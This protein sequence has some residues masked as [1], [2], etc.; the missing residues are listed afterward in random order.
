MSEKNI[1]LFSCNVHQ[2]ISAKI[3]KLIKQ[4]CCSK[5]HCLNDF[6]W[7]FIYI[8]V[9]ISVFRHSYIYL[10]AD[11][12]CWWIIIY[13]WVFE[14]GLHW[15]HWMCGFYSKWYSSF[16][17]LPDFWFLFLLYTTSHFRK[18]FLFCLLIVRS[19]CVIITIIWFMI[20]KFCR[21][22]VQMSVS[23]AILHKNQR[24]LHFVKAPLQK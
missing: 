5:L 4:G 17:V 13:I 1:Y 16:Q 15:Q 18:G 20:L 2:T 22:C 11:Q 21:V 19:Y 8:Y 14:M 10:Y 23:A 3:I 7:L 12:K 24:L 6:S 9:S